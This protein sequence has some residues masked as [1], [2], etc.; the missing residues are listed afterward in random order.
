M[1]GGKRVNKM[2]YSRHEEKTIKKRK[3]KK[4]EK[5]SDRYTVQRE[6]KIEIKLKW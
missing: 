6:R 4:T 2:K 5:E 3:E 1:G